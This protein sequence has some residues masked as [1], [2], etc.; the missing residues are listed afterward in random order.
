MSLKDFLQEMSGYSVASNDL[1]KLKTL[2]PHAQELL[3][4][5]AMEC[6]EEALIMARGA[7]KGSKQNRTLDFVARIAN[8]RFDAE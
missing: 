6:Y 7:E 8:K 3:S 2:T 4:R 1:T 5:K